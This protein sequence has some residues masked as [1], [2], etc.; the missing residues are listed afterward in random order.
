MCGLIVSGNCIGSRFAVMEIKTLAYYLLSEFY[1]DRCA[2]TQDPLELKSL[3]QCKAVTGH[4][5]DATN[6]F[7]VEL[8]RRKPDRSP[9]KSNIFN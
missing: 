5:M 8:R 3:P 1:I 6:G 9:Y 4:A 2:R 7:F